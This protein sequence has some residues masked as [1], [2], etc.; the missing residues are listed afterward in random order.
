MIDSLDAWQ[1]EIK[2]NDHYACIFC[3]YTEKLKPATNIICP[4]CKKNKWVKATNRK[5]IR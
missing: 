3:G 2:D 5:R 1:Q 4:E